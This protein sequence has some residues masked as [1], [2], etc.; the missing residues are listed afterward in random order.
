MYNV[1]KIYSIKTLVV[2]QILSF[3]R[4]LVESSE[5]AQQL[6]F[7]YCIFSPYIFL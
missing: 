2:V 7:L 5:F 6:M 4:D 1:E 3:Q